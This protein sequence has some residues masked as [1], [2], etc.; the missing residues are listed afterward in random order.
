MKRFAHLAGWLLLFLAQACIGE[1]LASW[2]DGPAKQAIMKFVTDVTTQGASTFVARSDRIAVF[3]NDG[4]LWSEQPLYFQF[5]FVVDRIKAMAPRHPEWNGREPFKSIL[6]GDMKTALAGGEKAA[7]EMMAAT[8]SGMT[9]EEFETQVSDWLATAR[10]RR[11]NRPYTELVFQPMLELLAYLRDNGFKTYVVSGGGI[12]FMRPWTEKVYG[13]PRE[14]VIGSQGKLQFEMRDGTP[15]LV[16]LPQIDLVDNGPGKPVGI[17]KHIGRRPLA[18]FGNSDADLEM[19]QWTAAGPGPH[20]AVLVHHTDAEREWAYDRKSNIGALDKAWD[21][22]GAKGWT[23][24]DMK[25]DWKKVFA[26][27]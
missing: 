27:E 1:S 5:M 16:K 17:W 21:Q 10:H 23:I 8:H 20:L 2:N 11:F 15:V 19:L 18:A 6:A 12:D 26:F 22:A 7:A 4:T 13:I 24:V 14:Q 9:T 3:D 25:R